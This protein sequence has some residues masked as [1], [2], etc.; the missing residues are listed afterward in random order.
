MC[1]VTLYMHVMLHY[2]MCHW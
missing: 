2:T 1:N